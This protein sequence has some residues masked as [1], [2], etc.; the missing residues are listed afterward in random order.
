MKTVYPQQNIGFT[1]IFRIRNKTF[2]KWESR[3]AVYLHIK[4]GVDWVPMRCLLSDMSNRCEW[5]IAVSILGGLALVRQQYEG[6]NRYFPFRP[7]V[8][9][10]AATRC[11]WNGAQIILY[12]QP[13]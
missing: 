12:T 8:Y 10:C 5:T 13:Y 4:L 6:R 2:P 1:M 7:T 11:H 3:G 9:D